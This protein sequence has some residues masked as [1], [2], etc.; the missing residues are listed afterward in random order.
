M[1]S[2]ERPGEKNSSK[3]KGVASGWRRERKGR[4]SRNLKVA[5]VGRNMK[6][7]KTLPYKL[8]SINHK[9]AKSIKCMCVWGG[10]ATE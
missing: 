8:Q 4:K 10:G 1:L 5:G 2:L 9:E 3:K 7:Y 6:N